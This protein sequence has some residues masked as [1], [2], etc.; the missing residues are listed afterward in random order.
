MPASPRWPCMAAP[1]PTCTRARYDTIRDIVNAVKLPVMANGDVTTPQKA[2]EILDYTGAA[3][4][5]VGRAAQGRPWL[6]REIGHYLETGKLLPEPDR[7][8]IRQV[9]LEH[10]D[11]L[12]SFY[13]E[14]SGVRIARKHIGWYCAGSQAADQ[15]TG[16]AINQVKAF[17]RNVMKVETAKEQKSLVS[18][19]F[20]EAG[21]EE[22]WEE[23]AA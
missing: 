11:K 13:G 4:I 12:Y 5:M 15:A 23:Q 10:L 16:S 19:F 18:R 1:A 6:F 3:A 2:K 8:E 17:R 9:L 14:F 21:L 22:T 7:E 20:S